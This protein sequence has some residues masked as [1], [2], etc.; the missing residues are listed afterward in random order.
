MLHWQINPLTMR[1]IMRDFDDGEEYLAEHYEE[2]LSNCKCQDKEDC[3]CMSYEKFSDDLIQKLEA[4]F[5]ESCIDEREE[6]A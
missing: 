6:Y 1:L 5:V 4:D 2:Y 3:E